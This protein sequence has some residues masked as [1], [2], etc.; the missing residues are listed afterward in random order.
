ML[1]A[2]AGLLGYQHELTSDSAGQQPTVDEAAQENKDDR[3]KQKKTSIGQKLEIDDELNQDDATAPLPVRL[4]QAELE[5][6][7]SGLEPLTC[8]LRVTIIRCRDLQVFATPPHLSRF[9]FSALPRVA[10]YCARGGVSTSIASFGLVR[11]TNLVAGRI[12]AWLT[13]GNRPTLG[14]PRTALARGERR[15]A[16]HKAFLDLGCA[17]I[18]WNQ[19]QQF[20]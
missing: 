14:A 10:P 1:T 15:A 3:A 19:V 2:A 20:C 4:R 18:C 17:L 16:V 13:T 7:T 11:L 12:S 9:L 6:P 8:L 5:E